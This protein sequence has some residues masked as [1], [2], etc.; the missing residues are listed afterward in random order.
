[1][2]PVLQAN[3]PDYS[4]VLHSL[5]VF[6][7]RKTIIEIGIQHGYTTYMLCEAAKKT[8]G[9]VYG[10][11]K[12][13]TQGAEENLNN[14]QCENVEIIQQNTQSEAFVQYFND[15]FDTIDFVFI[16]GDHSYGGVKNDFELVYPKLALD[17]ILVLHDTLKI[18]GCREF[19]LDVYKNYYDGTFDI[20]N[21]PFGYNGRRVGLS[22]LVKR[23]YTIV[24]INVDE[25]CGSLHTKSE[26]LKLEKDWHA[27]ET[28]KYKKSVNNKRD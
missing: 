19:L 4:H 18:D 10:I 22:I 13:T 17:G 15:K 28:T 23:S 16:D 1:M 24:D 7:N 21:L 8:G 5:I 27:S 2:D 3:I 20:I 6:T 14:W 9:T 25:V 26:I 11:D 12:N